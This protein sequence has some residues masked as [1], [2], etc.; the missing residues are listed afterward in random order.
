MPGQVLAVHRSKPPIGLSVTGKRYGH[1][2]PKRKPEHCKNEIAK[3][4]SPCVC[5]GNIAIADLRNIRGKV[6]HRSITSSVLNQKFVDLNRAARSAVRAAPK[7]RN[8]LAH[9]ASP[10]E[11]MALYPF[12]P[13]GTPSPARAGE[14]K[15]EREGASTHGGKL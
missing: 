11:G 14:G 12:P 6:L 4:V 1:K 5:I 7:G 9:G 3:R 2:E 8:I 10:G 13:S 15:G